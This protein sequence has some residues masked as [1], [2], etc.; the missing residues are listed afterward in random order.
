MYVDFVKWLVVNI[1]G[2]RSIDIRSLIGDTMR[3]VAYAYNK[4]NKSMCGH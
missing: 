3:I 2:L 1:P 4:N